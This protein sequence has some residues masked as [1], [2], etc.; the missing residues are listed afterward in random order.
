MINIPNHRQHRQHRHYHRHHH[1][2]H[3]LQQHHHFYLSVSHPRAC[4]HFLFPR[5]RPEHSIIKFDLVSR[6]VKQSFA[7]DVTFTWRPALLL[8]QEPDRLLFSPLRI[9]GRAHFSPVL[10]LA[11]LRSRQRF[12]SI[13]HFK[14]ITRKTNASHYLPVQRIRLCVCALGYVCDGEATKKTT[15]GTRVNNVRSHLT[16]FENSN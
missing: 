16:H 9:A 2:H 3:P 7:L 13:R 4:I 5:L 1:H 11:S 12:F 6:L 15:N 14:K 10:V 8:A